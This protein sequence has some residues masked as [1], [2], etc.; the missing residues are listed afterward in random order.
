MARPISPFPFPPFPCAISPCPRLPLTSEKG[1]SVLLELLLTAAVGMAMGQT[2]DLLWGRFYTGEEVLV[3]LYRCA[4]CRAPI[5]PVYALPFAAGI[6][7]AEGACPQCGEAL[8][9]R[10]VILPSAS[11][12]L[13]LVAYAAF[14]GN[15]GAALAG[16]FFATIFLT[17]AFTDLETGLL[18]NRIVYPGIL[19]AVAL[20]WAWPSTSVLAIFAGGGVAVLIAAAILLLSRFFGPEAFGLGDVKMIVLMGFVLGVPAVIIAVFIGTIAAGLG[21]GILL[22]TRLR[23]RSDYIP[24]GPFLALGAVIALFLAA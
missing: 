18:P 3:A 16:G 10:S 19:I 22:L 5:A 7:W 20:C 14:D 24:H 13:F 6:L 9:A 1:I 15:V 23:T 21:A 11:A 2:M 4:A 8:P 12:V 17:L